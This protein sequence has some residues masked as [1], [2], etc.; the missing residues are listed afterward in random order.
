MPYGDEY[1]NPGLDQELGRRRMMLLAMAQQKY[2]REMTR[3]Q[4]EAE[5]EQQRAERMQMNNEMSSWYGSAAQS[6]LGGAAIGS[7]FGGPGIGTAI[8]AGVGLVGGIAMEMK[9][10]RDVNRKLYGK[11][12]YGWDDAF[13]QTVG[14]APSL[15][16]FGK[17]INAGTSA[18]MLAAS[19]RRASEANTMDINNQMG[20]GSYNAHPYAD[21]GMPTFGQEFF[22]PPQGP[23]YESQSPYG[24]FPRP[25]PSLAT[26][27][28]IG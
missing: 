25:Y 28:G 10:R 13:G 15:N 24:D 2:N 3:K 7:A 23:L 5:A 27:Y 26:S 14:R 11:K 12:N 22:A 8:G 9:N 19:Q 16:E 4:A 6:T 21:G 17:M 18:A 1:Q 20:Y